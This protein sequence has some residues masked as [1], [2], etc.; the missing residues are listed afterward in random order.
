MRNGRK[1]WKKLKS[2]EKVFSNDEVKSCNGSR[3]ERKVFQ[4]AVKQIYNY[5]AEKFSETQK[6]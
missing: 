1:K 4:I 5:I 6:L 3:K 2:G